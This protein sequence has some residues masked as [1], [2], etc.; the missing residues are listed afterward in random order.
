MLAAKGRLTL[1]PDP[2]SWLAANLAPPVSLAAL[3]AEVALAS[4]SLPGFHGDP[5]DRIVVATAL[6][7]G[8]PLITADERIV[9]WNRHHGLLRVVEL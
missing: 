1:R 2:A 4:A 7:M 5:A 8:I 6:T 3:S 9:R